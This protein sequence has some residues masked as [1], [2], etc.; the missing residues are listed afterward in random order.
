MDP[1]VDPVVEKVNGVVAV[2]SALLIPAVATLRL[3]QS[4]LRARKRK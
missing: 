3:I 1:E 2:I 4:L